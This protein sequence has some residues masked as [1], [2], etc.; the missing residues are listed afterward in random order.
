[1]VVVGLAIEQRLGRVDHAL[2]AGEHPVER[3]AG[4]VP[5]GQANGA[6]LAVGAVEGA[7]VDLVVLVG[8][9]AQEVGFCA[10]EKLAGD[11]ETIAV[12]GGDLVC[13]KRGHGLFL[14]YNFER[15]GVVAGF[16]IG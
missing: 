10:V 14:R 7:L 11:I 5:D 12:V 15:A 4:V 2:A 1:V 6:A 13:G 8:G 3:V 9:A 16:V